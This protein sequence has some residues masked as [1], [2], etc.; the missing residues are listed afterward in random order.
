M[1]VIGILIV[2]KHVVS[3]GKD[4]KFKIWK[5]VDI[6]QKDRVKEVT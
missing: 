6:I 2:N 4:N 3:Y 5:K 1:Q